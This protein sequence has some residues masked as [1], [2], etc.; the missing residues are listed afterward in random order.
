ML[1]NNILKDF[2]NTP[3]YIHRLCHMIDLRMLSLSFF[4]L[5][6]HGPSFAMISICSCG[7]FWRNIDVS[8]FQQLSSDKC[9]LDL[10]WKLT[11]WGG[12]QMSLQM[13]KHKR[14]QKWLFYYTLTRSISLLTSVLNFQTAITDV[15]RPRMSQYFCLLC[16]WLGVSVS[17]KK[18][19]I[20]PDLL[21]IN[22]Q[23]RQKSTTSCRHIERCQRP[24]T[25]WFEFVFPFAIKNKHRF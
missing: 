22:G 23:L 7:S 9:E 16:N 1:S 12:S 17:N 13:E 5:L 14:F 2:R 25:S 6:Q 20:I 10:I 4:I 8:V 11:L 3:F 24:K 18:I 19:L 15:W 21:G